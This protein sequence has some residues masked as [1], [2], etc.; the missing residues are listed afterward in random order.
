MYIGFV[1]VRFIFFMCW[2][3]FWQNTLYLYLGSSKWILEYHEVSLV[4]I[5]S[6]IIEDMKNA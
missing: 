1:N 3:I 4:T 2:H 5:S 6:G